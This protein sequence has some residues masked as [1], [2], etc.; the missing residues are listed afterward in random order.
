MFFALDAESASAAIALHRHFRI[1]QIIALSC[2]EQRD[3]VVD[4]Q[5]LVSSFA[6]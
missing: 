2:L 3:Q 1:A 5:L 4:R 6:H